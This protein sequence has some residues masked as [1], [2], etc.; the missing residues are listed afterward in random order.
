[1]GVQSGTP[2]GWWVPRGHRDTGA[3]GQGVQGWG[4]PG[5]PGRGSRNMADSPARPAQVLLLCAVAELARPPK[6]KTF[7]VGF[8]AVLFSFSA[9]AIT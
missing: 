6:L 7:L 5:G 2:L 4:R 8:F 3:M 1:M 9:F